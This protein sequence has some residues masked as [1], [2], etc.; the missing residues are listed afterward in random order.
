MTTAVSRAFKQFI[1][2]HIRSK[3][4][5][6]LHWIVWEPD[7]IEKFSQLPL[8]WIEWEADI[9]VKFSHLPQRAMF[10]LG[11]KIL[12]VLWLLVKNMSA[13]YSADRCNSEESGN[14]VQDLYGIGGDISAERST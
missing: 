1:F 2:L 11:A 10:K 3:Q 4:Y 7:I 12:F 9:I 14:D 5:L 6:P 8:D 13:V